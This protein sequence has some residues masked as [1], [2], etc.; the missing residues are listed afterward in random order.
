MKSVNISSPVSLYQ[1]QTQY[2]D[3][4]N[5]V[6]VPQYTQRPSTKCCLLFPL[7]SLYPQLSPNSHL[8][9][10]VL[11]NQT[12]SLPRFHLPPMNSLSFLSPTK[13][14]L[15]I[16]TCSAGQA[17]DLSF[18]ALLG[19]ALFFFPFWKYCDSLNSLHLIQT[20]LQVDYSQ[21]CGSSYKY[22]YIHRFW[23]HLMQSILEMHGFH[24]LYSD[25]NLSR[26]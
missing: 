10:L 1:T 6:G 16:V 23:F 12:I 13:V 17:S 2:W 9:M 4:S 25:G 21:Q 24:L 20:L 19:C 5:E 14:L 18:I 22:S 15:C 11:R 7:I 26:R 3:I 8:S